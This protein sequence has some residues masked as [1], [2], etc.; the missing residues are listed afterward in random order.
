MTVQ[1]GRRETRHGFVDH[2]KSKD[3][4]AHVEVGLGVCNSACGLSLHP[5][6]QPHKYRCLTTWIF[7]TLVRI[8]ILTFSSLSLSQTLLCLRNVPTET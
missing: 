2:L 8:R 4:S 7:R 6:P 5:R 3:S 1:L